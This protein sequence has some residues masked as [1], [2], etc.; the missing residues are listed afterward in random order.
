M[1]GPIDF[2]ITPI[3][4]LFNSAS[5]AGILIYLL[6]LIATVMMQFVSFKLPT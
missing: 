4:G 5:G 6:I 2:T 3:S 1:I